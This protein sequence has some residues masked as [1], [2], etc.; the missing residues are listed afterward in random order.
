M[1]SVD[2][3]T[4]VAQRRYG[5]IEKASGRHGLGIY[6]GTVGLLLNSF[7]AITKIV[8]GVLSHS[9][10]LVADGVNNFSDAISSMVVILGMNI[11]R[12]PPDRKH[13][14]GHGRMEYVTGLVVSF[15]VLSIGVQFLYQSVL[16]I[17][18]PQVLTPQKGAIF[19][20]VLAMVIK[21]WMTRFYKKISK[22]TG[23]LTFEASATDA[24]S[25]VL[26]TS[27]V[28]LSYIIGSVT[29][30]PIDAYM[31]LLISIWVT[32]ESIGLIKDTLNPLLGEA[33]DQELIRKIEARAK[34]EPLVLGT[35][36]LFLHNYGSG[37]Y[38]GT[39][40]VEFWHDVDMMTIH[41]AL[42]NIEKDIESELGVKLVLH[43]DPIMTKTEEQ[44]TLYKELKRWVES[45]D[46]VLDLHDFRFVNKGEKDLV[47]VELTIDGEKSKHL[48]D[49]EYYKS[50]IRKIVNNHF[51]GYD[52]YMDIDIGFRD[53]PK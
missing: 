13:P 46:D 30:Y 1:I 49:K 21:L 7:L 11:A 16:R 47:C 40:D 45:R 48:E 31:G 4:K 38:M 6:A 27:V 23:S 41:D 37:K 32:K 18:E 24:I 5:S 20:M 3:L 19:F 25:D 29:K 52:L 9:I 15:L 50:E 53:E 39:M 43:M 44:K 51:P 34:E 8:F 42:D 35:H 17:I 12:K 28:L 36:D 14:Y 26:I 10:A 2:L 22:L 33:P